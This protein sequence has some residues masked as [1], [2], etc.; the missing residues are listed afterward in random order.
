MSEFKKQVEGFATRAIH[1]DQET[2]S[3]SDKQ[4][5]QPI[6]TTSIF[7]QTEPDVMLVSKRCSFEV[8]ITVFTFTSVQPHFYS[9]YSNPTRSL[10]EKCLAS[11]DGGNYGLAFSSGQGTVSSVTAILESGDHVLC[12]EGIYSGTPELLGNL[13]MKGVDF[14]SVDFTDLN[15][16]KQG[17]K[18]NTR[19][20][21]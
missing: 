19:V 11:L 20:G 15:N 17:I 7:R 10:L 14:D 1:V 12:A 3:W 9:R 18:S 5:V 8:C 4:I 6:V 13:K 16:V 2:E 21:V